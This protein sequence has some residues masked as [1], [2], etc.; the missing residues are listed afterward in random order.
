MENR[1]HVVLV[2]KA[3]TF[4]RS[5]NCQ[6]NP[7]FS[8]IG[9]LPVPGGT[10]NLPVAVGNLPTI[11]VPRL[12]AP[13]NR[14]SPNAPRVVIAFVK[15]K[16]GVLDERDRLGRRLT[17]PRVKHPDV[18]VGRREPHKFP[19][20]VFCGV[21]QLGTFG[22]MNTPPNLDLA[23]S[24]KSF[25]NRAAWAS[26]LMPVIAFGTLVVVSFLY[27]S[28]YSNDT[29]KFIGECLD[30]AFCVSIISLIL[31]IMSL[32]GIRRHGA[33]HILW[34]AVIGIIVSL[35]TGFI[36]LIGIAFNAL[37]HM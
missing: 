34:K 3:S 17:R 25:F 27:G 32:A 6:T 16:P 31:G 36:T 9:C 12:K 2:L 10:G 29:N 14:R 30:G 8:E 18:R 5:I 24:K 21:A 33:G 37:G 20:A 35:A 26:I 15:S 4:W 13:I 7:R 23:G 28:T 1:V 11:F 22:I 19:L